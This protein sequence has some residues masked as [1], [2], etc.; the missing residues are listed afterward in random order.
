MFPVEM[1][2]RCF[3]A[4]DEH[5]HVVGK[6]LYSLMRQINAEYHSVNVL[7]ISGPAFINQ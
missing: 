4:K 3:S 7:F 6:D 2:K 5:H 1:T